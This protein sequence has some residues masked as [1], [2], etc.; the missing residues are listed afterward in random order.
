M[1]HHSTV[2]YIIGQCSG[3][4]T[5]AVQGWYPPKNPLSK[6]LAFGACNR[7]QIEVFCYAFASPRVGNTAFRSDFLAG[8]GDSKP[9]NIVAVKQVDKC[10]RFTHKGDL[11]PA[12]PPPWL[13][14]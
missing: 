5:S 2:Q 4:K 14:G 1:V 10:Y 7:T 6:S 3:V 12:V 11:V 9:L 8:T 13:G